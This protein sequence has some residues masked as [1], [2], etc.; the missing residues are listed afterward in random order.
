MEEGVD[1]G[2]FARVELADYHQLGKAH[3]ERWSLVGVLRH[4][5]LHP[6][7]RTGMFAVRWLFAV[8]AVKDRAAAL[9]RLPWP[10][11]IFCFLLRGS[12]SPGFFPSNIY[13]LFPI[14]VAISAG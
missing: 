5:R 14:K 13:V 3:R 12:K 6:Q 9:A 10:C 2:R 1:A 7:S 8:P 11:N 4:R